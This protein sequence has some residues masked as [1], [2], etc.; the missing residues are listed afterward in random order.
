M[1]HQ[2]IFY[3]APDSPWSRWTNSGIT[4]RLVDGLR[5]RDMLE[6]AIS[7]H[8]R[9][10]LFLRTPPGRWMARLLETSL[11]RRRDAWSDERRGAVGRA[12]RRL[13]EGSAALYVF[14]YPE[15]DERLPIRRF[16][17]QDLPARLAY[18]RQAFGHVGDD[19]T[20]VE[21]AMRLQDEKNRAVDGTIAFGNFVGEAFEEDYGIPRSR[22]TAIGCGPFLRPSRRPVTHEGRYRTRRIL[23]VG[24]DWER[25][26]GPELL[27]AFSLV[28]DALPDSELVI[29]GVRDREIAAPGVRQIPFAVGS[30][31]EELFRSAS[32]FCVPSRC[33]TWGLVYSEAAHFA[34]PI[35]GF[36][37][38]AIPDIVIDGVTG[39]IA[40][41]RTVESLADSLIEALED[42]ARLRWMGESA[43]L[44]ARESLDWP[45]VVDRLQAALLPESWEGELPLPLGEVPSV[46]VERVAAASPRRRA[47]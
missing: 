20:M 3:V 8:A 4:R 25:K 28:R 40:P 16:L 36:R 5:E 12:L 2:K 22:V 39:L 17:L 13:P 14:I 10:P 43:L 7:R 33:E 37:E 46:L 44:Y 29:V 47:A 1:L 15:I 6:G 32:V 38:W 45:V 18:E 26:G 23:F 34:L 41:S 24:R 27:Q 35:V 11:L 21:R 30:E 42:P 19:P 31:L 9:L